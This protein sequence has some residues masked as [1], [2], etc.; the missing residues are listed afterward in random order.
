[1][2][3]A[4]YLPLALYRKMVDAMLDNEEELEEPS[5]EIQN[6]LIS[7]TDGEPSAYHEDVIIALCKDVYTQDLVYL[8]P[9]NILG[10]LAINIIE[11]RNPGYIQQCI[12][13]I[14]NVSEIEFAEE[15]E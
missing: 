2:N 15:E 10:K 6:W 9:D 4:N 7:D 1:M 13:N 14:F 5:C 12:A 8:N 3:F 11:K